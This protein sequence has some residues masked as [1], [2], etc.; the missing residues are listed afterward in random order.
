M[1]MNILLIK[2]RKKSHL[3]N[4]CSQESLFC[5]FFKILMYSFHYDVIAKIWFTDIDSS[6]YINHIHNIHRD[7]LPLKD[8]YFDTSDYAKDHFLYLAIQC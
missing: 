4:R 7:M 1:K 5:S 6:T 8:Q 2:L 3:T